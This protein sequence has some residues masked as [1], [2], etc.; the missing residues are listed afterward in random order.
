MK[1]IPK[2]IF[3]NF[4]EE[5]SL[6]TFCEDSDHI[7]SPWVEWSEELSRSSSM[8]KFMANVPISLDLCV[9]KCIKCGLVIPNEYKES[10]D[11]VMSLEE[12]KSLSEEEQWEVSSTDYVV[13]QVDVLVKQ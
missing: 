11:M 13:E 6:N 1:S 10:E 3:K 12:W 2:S 4:A 5:Y 9:K 7:F 8:S